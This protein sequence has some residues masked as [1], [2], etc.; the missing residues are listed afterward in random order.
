MKE[1]TKIS[2]EM[3]KIGNDYIV[4]QNSIFIN[5]RIP[6]WVML[7]EFLFKK[8]DSNLPELIENIKDDKMYLVELEIWVDS[9]DYRHWIDFKVL[10]AIII[11]NTY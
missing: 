1:T 4:C 2:F 10:K 3:V 9:D 7:G 11:K 5:G 6:N 8:E